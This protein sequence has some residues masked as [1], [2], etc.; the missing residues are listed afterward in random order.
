MSGRVPWGLAALCLGL[1]AAGCMPV[2]DYDCAHLARELDRCDL[3]PAHLACLRLEDAERRVLIER[4]EDMD[5]N[6]TGELYDDNADVPMCEL[7]DW[8]CPAPLFSVP[9]PRRTRYPIVLVGGID[10]DPTLSW[11]P[12]IAAAMSE[13]AVNEVL[14]VQPP[15]WAVPEV[16][17]EALYLALWTFFA[18]RNEEPRFNLV[19]WAVG[20]LDCRALVS[21]G[22]L[23][24]DRPEIADRAAS[25]VASITTIAT[26]HHGTNVADAA[27]DVV[28]G[29]AAA[30]LDALGASGADRPDD[31]Q[32]EAVL[33]RLTP[34]EM[35]DFN[36]R[37]VDHP[38]V[39]YF[40]YAGVS[41]P[42]AQPYVPSEAEVARA[43]TVDRELRW[44][45]SGDGYDVL[46]AELHAAAP[47]A[48]D[49]TGQ[50]GA[51]LLRPSDGMIAVSSAKWGD[52]RGCVP[53]DHYDLVGQIGDRGP[54]P[55]SG[56]EATT[57]YRRIA[58][59]LAR[60][61]L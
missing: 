15:A 42:F 55:N 56:F 46:A 39:Q 52:F 59:D 32:L 31:T 40:S 48:G 5:C 14:V 34:D 30:L 61:G 17:A 21:R 8:R 22:G 49:A 1:L 19:C 24:A 12:S 36:A 18:E 57:F 26:P 37:V 38:D 41:H 4:L 7:L 35:R 3:P 33:R 6:L 9:E 29:D 60:R 23:Y 58:A 20:G 45:R 50:D 2:G 54:D 47:Y 51:A 13:T 43:C 28:D 11:N 25:L 27:L 16:R 53:A 10:D 44:A